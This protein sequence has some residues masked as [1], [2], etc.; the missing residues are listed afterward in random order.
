VNQALR[1]GNLKQGS[2][3]WI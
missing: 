1:N 2:F 3:G